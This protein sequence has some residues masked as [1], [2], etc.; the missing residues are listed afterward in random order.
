MSTIVYCP[1]DFLH[2]Q[3]PA[4]IS[5]QDDKGEISW[6]ECCDLYERLEDRMTPSTTLHFEVHQD[7]SQ[8]LEKAMAKAMDARDTHSSRSKRLSQLR[9]GLMEVFKV[10]VF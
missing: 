2:S 8:Y 5:I 4:F 7:Y 9:F 10:P 6:K 3:L 1:D